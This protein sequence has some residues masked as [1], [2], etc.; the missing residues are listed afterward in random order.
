[1]NSV[2]FPKFSLLVQKIIFHEYPKTYF[3][4]GAV[5]DFLLQRKFTDVDIA[6]SATPEQV[7]KILKFNK[8]KFST[9]HEKFGVIVAHKGNSKVEISTF[10]TERYSNNRF[11][12]VRF[13]TSPKT[14]SNRRDFTI[15]AIYYNPCTGE[16]LDFH[17]GLEDLKNQ[18]IRLIGNGTKKLLEDPLRIIR[19]Y[20]FQIK[21]QFEFDSKTESVLKKY[22]T[23]TKNI[24]KLRLEKEIKSLHNKIL[25]NKLQ[26]VMHSIY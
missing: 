7:K 1:M 26:K 15:N 19:A 24:S 8:V 23:T 2:K 25:I 5:R 13:I 18:V 21:L 4:G 11:P 12:E 22:F 20:R 6:T 3:V 17:G 9:S 10:R 16:I 14:D